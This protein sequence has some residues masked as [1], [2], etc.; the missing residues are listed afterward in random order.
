MCYNVSVRNLAI[1]APIN[2]GVATA[3]KKYKNLEQ[4]F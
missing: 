3:M 2:L 1:I 4:I